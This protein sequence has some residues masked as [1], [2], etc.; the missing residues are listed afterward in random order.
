MKTLR[1]GGVP[2]HFNEPWNIAS[3]RGLFHPL[4]RDVVWSEFPGGTGAMLTALH[5]GKIDIAILLT[6]GAVADFARKRA[7]TALGTWVE[8]PLRWGIHTRPSAGIETRSQVAGRRIAISR[9][10]SGSHL[11][12]LLLLDSMDA[13]TRDVDFVEVGGI[14]GAVEAFENGEADVFLWE[15]TMT[16]PLVDDGTF[17]YIGDFSAPWP[18]FTF[19]CLKEHETPLRA[20]YGELIKIMKPLCDELSHEPEETAALLAERHQIQFAD[21]LEWLKSTTWSVDR[22]VDREAVQAA[23]EALLKAGAIEGIPD[24]RAFADG[25][26]S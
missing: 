21:V 5:E 2:E 15:R 7:T 1:I 10:T 22:Q 18:A 13:S 12:A 26:E 16:K 19:V 20:I 14:D 3:E 9:P 17:G 24:F 25:V 23:A 11:M 4:E 6:E 8:T